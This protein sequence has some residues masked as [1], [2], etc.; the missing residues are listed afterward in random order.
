MAPSPCCK[1]PLAARFSGYTTTWSQPYQNE[2]GAGE[3]DVLVGRGPLACSCACEPDAAGALLD[4]RDVLRARALPFEGVE[5]SLRG[6]SLGARDLERAR[7]LSLGAGAVSLRARDLDR[8]RVRS[9]G[10]GVVSLGARD[11]DLE[12]DLARLDGPAS[13]VATI[14]SGRREGVALLRVLVTEN[15]VLSSS[16]GSDSPC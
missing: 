3:E 4:V 10:A 13:R 2:K 5:A 7:L 8:A 11:L 14:V 6:V 1:E 9:L 12:R 15:C 16:S